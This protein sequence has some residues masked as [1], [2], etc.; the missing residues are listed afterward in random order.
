METFQMPQSK[1]EMIRLH[2]NSKIHL[3]VF[4]E[5]HMLQRY[6]YVENKR[7]EKDIHANSNHKSVVVAIR[8]EIL[9][10]TKR[11]NLSC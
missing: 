1:A 3:Y 11:Y 6:K 9:L 8:Q 10:E 7:M 5:R 2:K 4:Y